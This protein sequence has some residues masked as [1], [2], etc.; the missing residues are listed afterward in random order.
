MK[1]HKMTH[2]GN[3][4]ADKTTYMVQLTEGQ[5]M[6]TKAIT[7][8]NLAQFYGSMDKFR[9]FNRRVLMTE[10]AAFLME[11]GAGWLIDAVASYITPSILAKVTAK[12]N[13]VAD[14]QFWTLDV[15]NNTA[16]L[17][18]KADSDEPRLIEQEIEYTD[19]PLP[20]I[21]LYAQFDGEYW[22]IMLP[23]EY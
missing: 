11:N 17:Y 18:M 19:F 4:I 7:E 23:S 21:K 16:V 14:I 1:K 12:D 6:M 22:T 15:K 20:T 2:I 9:H 3:V 8:E 5:T 13:R 10:G